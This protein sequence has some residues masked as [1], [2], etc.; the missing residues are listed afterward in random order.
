[1]SIN[2]AQNGL[3]GPSERAPGLQSLE[4]SILSAHSKWGKL[5]GPVVHAGVLHRV[6]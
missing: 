1:M 6:T 3:K 4:N 2:G 5:L